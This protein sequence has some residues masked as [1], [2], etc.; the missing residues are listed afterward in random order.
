M[1]IDTDLIAQ[2][3]AAFDGR[4]ITDA[5]DMAPFL[6]DWRKAWTGVA[7]AV[8]QP[9]TAADVAK[10]VA[11]CCANQVAV[12]P[13]GGNTGL[14]GGSVPAAQGRNIV[15]S[16]ARLNR[17]R[18]VDPVNGT[19]TVEA[20]VILQ[21]AQEAAQAAERLFPLSL[22]SEGSCTVGGNLATNAGGVAVL[23]YGNARDLCLGLE[24]VTPQGELW[25]GLRTLRKDNT[26][27]DLRD[28][29]IGSE[30]TLGVITAA[31][32]KLYPL[33][34][35]RVVAFAAVP[36]P[37]AAVAL[38]QLSQAR[39]GSTLTAFELVSK[40]SLDLV[41]KHRADARAPFAD[42]SPWNV[43]LELSAPL[44][45]GQGR[46][47]LETLLEAAFEADLATDAVISGS[48]SQSAAL[49]ALREGIGGAQS[50]EGK[51]IKHDI[52]VPISRIAQF[53]DEGQAAI[54]A[55]EPAAR[56]MTFGHLGDGNLHF[57][58]SAPAGGDGQAFMA[59]QSAINLAIHDL[60]DAYDGSISAEHGLGLL[61]RDEA[62]RYR[63]PLET[64]LMRTL[65][66]ALDPQ[67][68]MNPGK[69]LP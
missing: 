10:V 56:P 44:D 24:V 11:W 63:S 21:A 25:D 59:L 66:D 67:N 16:L 41:L 28:L 1:S 36:S 3:D 13:Q 31:V 5:R 4:L 14:A 45:E 26:G 53:I 9:D 43:L 29:Y 18:Q 15:L 39:L 23:R 65:K 17:V 61:R 7:L 64:R 12:T 38:L 62:I 46:T 40:P 20:G 48:L 8:A 60:V 68:V 27:Y 2:L 30:G 50:A 33:P 52:S 54:L 32:M 69:V 6:A 49:W 37:A 35:A 57:N 51:S 22:A 34:A 42:A 55:I 47:E 19:M 58:V